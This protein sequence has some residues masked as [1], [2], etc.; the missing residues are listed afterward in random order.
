MLT[1]NFTAERGSLTLQVAFEIG[2]GELVAVLGPNGAGKSTLLNCLAGLVPISSGTIAID[3]IEVDCPERAILTPPEK[4]PIGVVFQ[5]GLLF[6]HMT[7]IENVA[8]GLRAHG[9]KRSAARLEARKWIAKFGL[10]QYADE[11]PRVL[12]GG[13]AQRV[14][15][16]RA[17]I[18]NPRLLL[19]DEPLASLDAGT[20][21][22]V[23]MELSKQLASFPGMR[24]MVTHDPIDAH[25]LADR[26]IILEHGIITQ[27]GTPQE[28]TARPKTRYVAELAGINMYSGTILNN[29]LTTPTG[30]TIVTA[31]DG[32]G[33]SHAVIRPQ[34]ISIHRNLDR[35]S[36]PRNVWPGVITHIDNL[37][38][39][40]RVSIS[41]PLPQTVEVTSTSVATLGLAPGEDIWTSVKAT[42]I[43]TYP[44]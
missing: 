37:G 27:I 39:R 9:T 23:R 25:S 44:A 29:V 43:E 20:R 10:D 7:V 14:A 32:H 40:S 8:F 21:N 18:T 6:E 22:D 19:L 2:A 34:S 42:D 33:P 36:S 1:A 15:L 38:D 3:G 13:Q 17:L 31:T 35:T 30:A 16:A 11:L 12:S 24:I 26:I 5:N 41:G 28:I 4:R